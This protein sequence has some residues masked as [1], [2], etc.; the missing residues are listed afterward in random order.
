MAQG[1]KAFAHGI[2]EGE[3]ADAGGSVAHVKAEFVAVVFGI[4]DGVYLH[5]ADLF[6]APHEQRQRTAF[7]A[8]ALYELTQKFGTFQGDAVHHEDSVA[9]VDSGFF[10]RRDEVAVVC[11]NFLYSDDEKAFVLKLDPER[12]APGMDA[13]G[14]RGQGFGGVAD[15]VSCDGRAGSGGE[16]T[17][18]EE[19]LAACSGTLATSVVAD[20]GGKAWVPSVAGEPAGTAEE[21]VGRTAGAEML[22]PATGRK[23][24]ART[25]RGKIRA[26]TPS[27][28]MRCERTRCETR[29]H[30]TAVPPP[31]LARRRSV[32][33][34]L[35]P[36]PKSFITLGSCHGKRTRSLC[37]YASAA[38]GRCASLPA[39]LSPRR[40]SGCG[41]A[42]K[43]SGVVARRL[44]Y[45]TPCEHAREFPD[46]FFLAA[47][48]GGGRPRLSL[49]TTLPREMW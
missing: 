2:D 43:G 28:N 8:R 15:S 13:K 44:R 33:A 36:P 7:C 37:N 3:C 21:K 4:E 14:G 23:A 30:L 5:G 16:F 40:E 45:G 31:R 12:N 24:W 46:P 38:S 27:E 35:S 48:R 17:G 18:V 10:T 29:F 42:Q 25:R 1:G 26:K 11:G 47:K 39:E 9:H 32:Y 22:S 49:P 41:G 6:S 19:K 20:G 34:I